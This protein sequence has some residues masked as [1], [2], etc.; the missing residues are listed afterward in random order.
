MNSRFIIGGDFSAKHTPWGSRLITAKGRELYKA[1]ADTGCEIVS[2]SK[3]P[4]WPTDPKK[5]PDLLDFFVIKNISTN[6]IKIEEGFDLSS[7]HSPIYLTISDKIIMKDQNPVLT[8]K[9]TD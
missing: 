5:I 7:D 8:N 1:V 9:H 2:N 3:P 6:C 4:Y